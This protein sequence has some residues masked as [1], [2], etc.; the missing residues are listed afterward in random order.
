MRRILSLILIPLFT[1]AVYSPSAR[2]A[3]KHKGENKQFSVDIAFSG[4]FG[5][6]VTDSQ[7]TTYSFWG[8]SIFEP[9]IYPEEYWGEFPLYFWNTHIGVA[10][11]ITNHGPRNRMKLKVIREAYTL[12]TDGTNGV[13]L[14]KPYTINV[15]LGRGETATIDS[16]FAA[17]YVAGAE[18]GLDRFLVKIVHVNSGKGSGDEEPGLI[19][20]KEGIFCPP[21]IIPDPDSR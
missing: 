19:A 16:S 5:E 15:T 8:Y 4:E 3:G 20:V 7:G 21:E 14:I 6:T 2:S 1:V 11:T 18:S 13:A 9:K 12:R 10:V 17:H